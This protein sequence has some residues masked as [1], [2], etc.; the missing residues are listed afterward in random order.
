MHFAASLI[1]DLLLDEYLTYYT[2]RPTICQMEF[3]IFLHQPYWLLVLCNIALNEISHKMAQHYFRYKCFDTKSLSY[4]VGWYWFY[5]SWFSDATTIIL[6]TVFITLS[7]F[8]KKPS[9]TNYEM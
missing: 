4:S 2:R 9:S 1:W 7:A 5:W 6:K 3:I 8:C